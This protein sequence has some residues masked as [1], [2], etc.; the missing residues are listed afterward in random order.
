[1]NALLPIKDSLVLYKKRPARVLN[2]GERLEIEIEPNSQIRV[3]AKDV[4]LLHPGPLRD[5][6]Q[7]RALEGDADLAW[8]I[9]V[10]NSAPQTLQELA[11]LVYGEFTPQTA[12]SAW[13][14]LD[15]GLYFQGN[16][17]AIIPR[18]TEALKKERSARTAKAQET[19]AWNEFL[20]LVQAGQIDSERHA[21][22]L[23]E[24][25]DLALGRR[26]DSRLLRELGRSER[27]EIAH[28]LLI[29][30]G[31]WDKTFNPYPTRLGLAIRT[32]DFPIPPKLDE[33][34]LDLS[35]LMAFAVDDQGNQDPD[36]AISL[37][38]CDFDPAGRF[39]GGRIWVH[40]ADPGALIQIDSPL[41]LEARQH[42][43]TLYLPEGAVPMLPPAAIE[44]LGLG[45]QEVSP[46][47]SFELELDEKAE[48]RVVRA[49]PSLVRVDRLS[50]EQ[51]EERLDADPFH[52]LVRITRAYEKRRKA[53]S[54]LSIDLPEAIVRANQGIVEIRP[55]PHLESRDMVREAM[56]MA[57]EAVAQFAVEHG[58]PFPFTTQ[59]PPE[60][61]PSLP[62]SLRPPAG[63]GSMSGRFAIRR[64]MKRSQLHSHPGAHAGLGLPIYSRLTSPLRRYPDLLAHQQLRCFLRGEKPLDEQALQ[65]R[66]AVSEQASLRIPQVESL[67]RRHWTL[68]Y[69]S[70]N[71][72][73]KGEAILVEKKGLR[74]QVILTELAYEAAI[75]LRSDLPLDSLLT[76][77]PRAVDIPALEAH[78]SQI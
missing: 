23:R 26:E 65:H 12:W 14:L 53:N 72:N 5:L 4:I 13:L 75:H 31:Y 22:F 20:L 56:L 21:R 8:Q 64:F 47:L 54:A 60:L 43:A 3:R 25:E 1:M 17:E 46:A 73:W 36:D 18:P 49:Q 69:L 44:R 40:V 71:P 61:P 38:S 29:Q 37:I 67:S 6:G 35:D 2:T 70:Q 27:P 74:G 50:Y 33:P 7:I 48:P 62:E 28:A 57:G 15:D 32:P 24:T 39:L 41:D 30:L 59:D 77:S 19:R 10:E 51:A 58:I 55:L 76:L 11:L 52:Q 45:L 68:V 9:L 66:I 42:G 78:F 63:L 34:R 16:P